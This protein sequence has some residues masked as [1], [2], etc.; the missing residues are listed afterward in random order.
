MHFQPVAG[1]SGLSPYFEQQEIASDQKKNADAFTQKFLDSVEECI[2]NEKNPFSAP[3]R[4]QMMQLIAELRKGGFY[5]QT[6]EET[7]DAAFV[8]LQSA[9]EHVIATQKTQQAVKRIFGAIHTPLPATPLCTEADGKMVEDLI[10]PELRNNP[11]KQTTITARAVSVRGML[12]QEDTLFYAI[13]PNGGLQKRQQNQQEIFQ[14]EVTKHN[15][16]LRLSELN[17]T[18][19][20]PAAVG[21]LYF[22]T[23]AQGIPYAFSIK[24][25]Q[26][27]VA[28]HST[29]EWGVWFG[30]VSHPEVN[31]RIKETTTYIFAHKGPDLV[32]EFVQH[33]SKKE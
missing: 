11:D 31:R 13:Y 32:A 21:A 19:M 22:L 2:Q 26:A 5:I 25:Q 1:T 16:K 15:G 8:G 29:K 14:A 4:A 10:A 20:D 7:V 12:A 30:V 28:L 9:I 23:D 17:C 18:E 3:V 24:A 6:G 33:C 27:N